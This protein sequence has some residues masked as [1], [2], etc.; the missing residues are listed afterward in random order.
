M[1]NPKNACN[2]AMTDFMLSPNIAE[3]NATDYHGY[4]GNTVRM[5][6]TD[7]FHAKPVTVAIT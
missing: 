6:V 4:D 3:I 1:I 7:D 2:V 5:H